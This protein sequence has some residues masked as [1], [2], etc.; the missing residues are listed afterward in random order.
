MTGPA[1]DAPDAR[2]APEAAER[3]TGPVMYCY[4]GSAEA[5]DA[6][7]FA[8]RL[9]RE[10]PAVVA[11]LWEA[12]SESAASDT[13]YVDLA[14]VEGMEP[15][16]DVLEERARSTAADGCER[17]RALG[18]AAEPVAIGGSGRPWRD[19]VEAADRLDASVIV[20]GSRGLHGL[21]SLLTGSVSHGLAAHAGRPVLI[22][23]RAPG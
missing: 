18:V 21:R 16:M 2:A 3:R 14:A 15:L 7:A 23:P 10:H 4:D 6:L 8:A 9:L 5:R 1:Q 17:L 11:C 19:L 20:V 22:V 13:P 12:P